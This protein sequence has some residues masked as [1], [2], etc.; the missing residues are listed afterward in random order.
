MSFFEFPHT[1][2]Y[3]NDLGWLIAHV[4]RISKQLENFINYNSIKYADPIAWNITTQYEA[5]TVVIDPQTGTAYISTRPV[6]SGILVTNTDYWT[7]IF[8][9][10]ESMDTL[11]EQIAISNEGLSPTATRAYQTGELVWLQDLLYCTTADFPAGTAFIEGVNVDK[12]TVEDML[13]A[14]RNAITDLD[15]NVAASLD[16]LREQIAASN[17]GTSTT[18]TRAYQTGELVWLLDLLYITTADIPAGTAFIEGVNVNGVTI[19]DMLTALRT[20]ITN[21]DN[22]VAEIQ[23]SI[24]VTPEMYGAAGDGVTDDTQALKDAFTTGRPV[25]MR[26]T[27]AVSDMCEYAGTYLYGG[28]KIKVASLQSGVRSPLKITGHNCRVEDLEI[29]CNSTAAFGIWAIVTGAITIRSCYI[30]HTETA[31]Y[32]GDMS[33]AGIAIQEC[34]SAEVALC[35]IGNINRS[36]GIAGTHGSVGIL[37]CATKTAYVHDCVVSGVRSSVGYPDCDGIYV[38]QVHDDADH[39]EAIVEN[40]RIVDCTGRFVKSQTLYTVVRNNF[41]FLSYDFL[42]N[43][44]YFNCVSIQRGSFEIVNNYFSLR[45]SFHRSYSRMFSLEIYNQVPRSGIIK[46]NTIEGVRSAVTNRWIRSYLTIVCTVANARVDIEMCEN[47]FRAF[48]ENMVELSTDY[49]V[50]GNIK[51]HHNTTYA[52]Q[53]LEM[54]TGSHHNLG[55]VL[56]D[57]RYND[58]TLNTST[59]R[60]SD[61]SIL[62]KNLIYRYNR[63]IDETLNNNPLSYNDLVIFEGFYRGAV[64]MTDIPSAIGL[65]TYLYLNKSSKVCEFYCGGNGN[66]GYVL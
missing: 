37:V 34:E 48:S 7:P 6:P 15:N 9:Y 36:S 20:D 38:T 33:A 44:R 50:A 4:I 46:A 18:A 61:I 12:V 17:E 22:E 30:H 64:P 60:F 2:T 16:R 51:V 10:A 8:N 11:R 26:N 35:T 1:R 62:F 55:D 53:V 47:N 13:N 3:D 19:E 31:Y 21:L 54:L 66:S 59:T 5:N 63:G 40:N 52:Y 14:L 23:N 57:V 28:G 43:E 25:M 42:P 24:H 39:T 58:N 65:G 56:L 49:N 27:Y 29:D 32:L 41:C 45:E